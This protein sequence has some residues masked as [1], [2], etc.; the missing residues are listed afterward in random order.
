MW[1]HSP[2]KLCSPVRS[3]CFFSHENKE[4]A[5]HNLIDNNLIAE[6]LQLVIDNSHVILIISIWYSTS[7]SPGVLSQTLPRLHTH[8]NMHTFTQ[9]QLKLK[10]EGLWTNWAGLTTA[11]YIW[12]HSAAFLTCLTC[13]MDCI[14]FML[15]TGVRADFANT[16]K[17]TG[18]FVRCYS[19]SDNYPLKDSPSGRRW[20]LYGDVTVSDTR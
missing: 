7:V 19:L 1:H 17:D 2:A 8:T 16:L 15:M 18:F 10:R 5:L 4:L 14:P 9:K 12:T 20:D 13:T 6:T 3:V 11:H